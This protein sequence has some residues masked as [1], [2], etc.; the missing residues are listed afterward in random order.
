MVSFPPHRTKPALGDFALFCGDRRTFLLPAPPRSAPEVVF[1]AASFCYFPAQGARLELVTSSLMQDAIPR[2][3]FCFEEVLPAAEAHFF[4]PCARRCALRRKAERQ[5]FDSHASWVDFQPFRS[6]RRHFSPLLG[7][8]ASSPH[9]PASGSIRL[10]LGGL[11]ASKARP[12]HRPS[13]P[14]AVPSWLAG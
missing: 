12:F 11:A 7:R 4:S 5:V 8:N 6:S 3:F 2:C 9:E 1:Q 13:G 14:F 10:F